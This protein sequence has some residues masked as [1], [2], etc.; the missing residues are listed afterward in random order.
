MKPR[1]QHNYAEEINSPEW[2][3][4]SAEIKQRDQWTCQLCGC[5][6]KRLLVHHR[7]YHQGLPYWEY[8]DIALITYCE[9]CHRKILGMTEVE[10]NECLNKAINDAL[11]NHLTKY[12]IAQYIDFTIGKIRRNELFYGKAEFN[13]KK[14]I[15]RYRF[16][17]FMGDVRKYSDIYGEDYLRSFIDY[18]TEKVG[19][20]YRFQ[21][22]ENKFV[23]KIAIKE[24]ESFR[25]AVLKWR[26]FQQSLSQGKAL[27]KEKAPNNQYMQSRYICGYLRSKGWYDSYKNYDINRPINMNLFRLLYEFISLMKKEERHIA[28]NVESLPDIML[29]DYLDKHAIAHRFSTKNDLSLKQYLKG[30]ILKVLIDID[31]NGIYH[32]A[33]YEQ[34]TIYLKY[35]ESISNMKLHIGF[36]DRLEL[37]EVSNIIPFFLKKQVNEKYAH[38]FYIYYSFQVPKELMYDYKKG[39]LVY[40]SDFLKTGH[41]EYKKPIYSDRSIEDF[42][43]ILPKQLQTRYKKDYQSRVGFYE[44]QYDETPLKE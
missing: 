28:H 32:I 40:S 33:F 18:W 20:C 41:I 39:H 30:K 1:H 24:W 19:N 38:N 17:D 31:E 21:I 4:V 26:L 29:R 34:A 25:Y 7:Y 42:L 2:H 44:L 15:K 13:N 12:E 27:A 10:Q 5:K 9:D 16:V 8:P 35:I 22:E 37:T 3:K 23:F 6:N 11:Y 43:R 14:V 36:D